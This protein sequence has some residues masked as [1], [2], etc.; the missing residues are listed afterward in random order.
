V[1]LIALLAVLVSCG[2]QPVPVPVPKLQPGQW[3]ADA[4]VATGSTEGNC[5][6]VPRDFHRY[7]DVGT[8]HAFK[9]PLPGTID[10]L[11]EYDADGFEV[12]C[13]GL[14]SELE[15]HGVIWRDGTRAEGGGYA[16]GDVAGC[17][18]VAFGFFL[19]LEEVTP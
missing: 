18:R 5:A 11:T 8:D 3:V 14:G 19:E 13:K 9:S 12:T 16:Q 6:W 17:K 1:K 7:A 4:Y 2:A 10:C 15:A